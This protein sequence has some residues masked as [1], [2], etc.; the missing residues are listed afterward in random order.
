VPKLTAT[1]LDAPD[2]QALARFYRDLLGWPL[3]VDKPGWATL[4]PPGGGAGLSFQD[5]AGHQRPT[6]PNTD[7]RQQ[8]QAHLD[9][10]VDDLD[11]ACARAV[12]LGATIADHQPQDHVRVC[13]DP[14]G[15]PFCLYVES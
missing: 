2:A 3:D 5:S 9:I 11:Q 6:W 4:R 1:V 12:E 7:G 15:H 8:M 14:A 13:L 10:Q